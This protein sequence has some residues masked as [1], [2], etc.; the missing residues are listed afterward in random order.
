LGRRPGED[1]RTIPVR[2]G[3]DIPNVLRAGKVRDVVLRIQTSGAAK[4]DA[5]A[6]T[7][8]DAPSKVTENN[9]DNQYKLPLNPRAVKQ[10]V[11]Q[12]KLK[13]AR[14]GAS[15]EKQ[16]AIEHVNVEVRYQRE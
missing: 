1:A 4:K 16:L 3:D 7:F 9:G 13:I 6:V 14:R 5:L 10:G 8:N 12:L 15:A 11:N 2:I